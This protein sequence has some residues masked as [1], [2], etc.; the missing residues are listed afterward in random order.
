MYTRIIHVHKAQDS[1]TAASSMY[2]LVLSLSPSPSPPPLPTLFPQRLLES[3]NSSDD[4]DIS[5][6]SMIQPQ[7]GGAVVPL[8]LSSSVDPLIELSPREQPSPTKPG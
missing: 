3:L 6:E 5:H 2:L 4:A 8:S 1:N 7:V